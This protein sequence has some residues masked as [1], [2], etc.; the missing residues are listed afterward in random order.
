MSLNRV[1]PNLL[2]GEGA[3]DFAYEYGMPTV[4]SDILVSNGARDRWLRWRH[5]LDHVE[6]RGQS[7]ADAMDIEGQ[8]STHDSSSEGALSPGRR[9]MSPD[10]P[11]AAVGSGYRQD[12]AGPKD[13]DFQFSGV[14]PDP[15]N[16]APPINGNCANR[17]ANG[18]SDIAEHGPAQSG[19][20]DETFHHIVDVQ[21]PAGGAGV[22][23]NIPSSIVSPGPVIGEASNG[24]KI[25]DEINDTVGAIAIDWNGNIAA[26]SS[27]GGIGM[28]HCGRT[29]PAALVG[30]GTAV[31]PVDPED[32]METSAAAVASGTG[33][34]MATT[35]AAGTCAERIYSSI[36]K[37]KGEP[38]VFESVSE[39]EAL[40]AMVTKD[41]MGMG[42]KARP[43][44]SSHFRADTLCRSSSCRCQSLSCC[45]RLDGG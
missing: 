9:E 37:V 30:I 2:V 42:I 43:P 33:E 38:G 35:M 31:I 29:G 44:R 26:G 1:P 14:E 12:S 19:S 8:D 16:M 10:G 4:P 27:S 36:R 39:D 41:F 18:G 40:E 20:V 21:L 25:Y 3:T 32:E 45:H 22:A 23:P 6:G 17:Y 5:E 7:H 15:V 34:H 28:K 24:E 13:I 11:Q